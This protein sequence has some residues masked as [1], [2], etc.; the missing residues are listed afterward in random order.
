M[1]A[2]SSLEKRM[3]RSR[4]SKVA[5]G[6]AAALTMASAA[7]VPPGEEGVGVVASVEVLR[8]DNIFRLPENVQPQT[9][10]GGAE[11][12]ADTYGTA[13]LNAHFDTTVSAQRFLGEAT[14]SEQ[15]FKNFDFLNHTAYAGNVAWLWRVGSNFDGRLAYDAQKFMIA[16]GTL[17]G[18]VLSTTPNYLTSRESIVAAGYGAQSPIR[19]RGEFSHLE[20]RNQN[21]ATASMDRDSIEVTLSYVSSSENSI[22]LAA[23]K[24][25]GD[26][27]TRLSFGG[28]IIDSSYEQTRYAAV[29]DWTPVVQSHLRAIAGR[30]ERKYVQFPQ[31]NYSGWMYDVTYEWRPKDRFTLAA[32]A[33]RGLS[34]EEQVDI[35]HVVLEA[36]GLRPGW[37]INDKIYLTLNAEQSH[38]TN[39]GNP[40]LGLDFPSLREKVWVAGANLSYQMTSNFRFAVLYR[41]EARDMHAVPAEYD[42]KAN[43]AG[44]ELRAVF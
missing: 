44:L 14:I 23:R 35:G 37:Q 12:K 30:N 2:S 25:E 34:V 39:A 38:R 9:A 28:L 27:P 29:L 3:L 42:Y 4:S 15:R 16:L 24:E 43:V 40:R 1:H 10:L 26:L 19:L 33:R 22:G 18:G 17:F 8:D 21:F 13:S 32:L 11:S 41:H 20:R 36:F 31:R 6:V 5:L 7:A